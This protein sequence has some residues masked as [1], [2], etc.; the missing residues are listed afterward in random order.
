MRQFI[1]AHGGPFFFEPGGKETPFPYT[2]EQALTIIAKCGVQD[3]R[4]ANVGY[5]PCLAGQNQPPEI[6]RNDERGRQVFE[7]MNNITKGAELNARY[8]WEGDEVVIHA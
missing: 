4:I 2:P 6:L 5:L 1:Q 8:D 7:Y 3:G